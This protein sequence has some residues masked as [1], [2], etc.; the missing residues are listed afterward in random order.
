[1]R[2]GGN[3]VRIIEQSFSHMFNDAQRGGDPAA[4]RDYDADEDH[5]RR[6]QQQQISEQVIDRQLDDAEDK[7]DRKNLDQAFAHAAA[8]VA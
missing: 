6:D 4:I 5:S 3:L 2:R 7:N 8:A 1:V